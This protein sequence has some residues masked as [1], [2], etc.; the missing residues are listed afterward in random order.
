MKPSQMRMP[1]KESA[2]DAVSAFER[3]VNRS[4]L[5]VAFRKKGREDANVPQ[6]WKQMLIQLDSSVEQD[7]TINEL[8]S[9]LR[10][11]KSITDTMRG[12]TM[13]SLVWIIV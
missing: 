9:L 7:K 10:K 8:V 6:S 4:Q 11:K 3:K 12:R 13:Q 2:T 1:V 5:I